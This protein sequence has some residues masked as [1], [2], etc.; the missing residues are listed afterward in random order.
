MELCESHTRAYH[1]ETAS[2][3]DPAWFSRARKVG[4]TA[5][6]ST[7]QWVVDQVVEAVEAL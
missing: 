6:A 4:V 1:V 7:P 2:E 3:L 5:G